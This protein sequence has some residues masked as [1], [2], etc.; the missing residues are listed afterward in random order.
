MDRLESIQMPS[1][2]DEEK[3]IIGKS[4]VYP[5]IRKEAGL[6]PE[7]LIIDDNIWPQIVRPLGFDSGI[8]TLERT[9]NGACRK[10]ARMIVEGKVQ[11]LHITIENVKQFLSIW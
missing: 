3:I 11:S 4:Y 5:K 2:S 1:Y 6:T 8:R 7:Q 10:A 9:I